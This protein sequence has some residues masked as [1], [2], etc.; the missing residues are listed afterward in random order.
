MSQ[1]ALFTTFGTFT[2]WGGGGGG[3]ERKETSFQK[4][5]SEKETAVYRDEPLRW[6]TER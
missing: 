4:Y 3:V 5:L 6:V 1:E 2:S